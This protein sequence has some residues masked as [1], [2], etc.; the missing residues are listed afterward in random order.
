[1]ATIALV[2][3]IAQEQRSADLLETE[4]IPALAGGIR[5]AG[6]HDVADSMWRSQRPGSIE[7]RM[8]FYGNEFLKPGSQGAN[9]DSE[10]EIDEML[11]RD[12]VPEWLDKALE[13]SNPRDS[14]NAEIEL[15]ALN[16]AGESQGVRGAVAL[17]FNGLDRIPWM[18]R[19]GI[20]VAGRFNK[21]LTQV[22]AYLSNPS[23]RQ[24]ILSRVAEVIDQD[25]KI[26]V[27]HSLGSVVAYEL[28]RDRDIPVPLFVTLGSPLALNAVRTRLEFQPKFPAVKNWVNLVDRDDVVAARPN[29]QRIFDV[30]RPSDSSFESTYT[31]DNGSSP[32]DAR[33]YLGKKRVGASIADVLLS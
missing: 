13:S 23:L 5:N 2:H 29:I 15:A 12:L 16:S 14:G 9:G 11:I 7:T 17:M 8:A 19:G 4:W 3:G 18:S 25:T 31:V 1:M 10:F 32:H 22:G 30:E 33:F 27:S 26:V 21:A 20:A 28:L 6:F 24:S